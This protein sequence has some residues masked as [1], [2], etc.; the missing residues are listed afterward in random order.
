M[1][2]LT[3]K[4]VAIWWSFMWR[5]M[6]YGFVIGFVMGM[7]YA[8]GGGNASNKGF[9]LLVQLTSMVVAGLYA[10]KGALVKNNIEIN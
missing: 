6:I 10:M 9:L 2:A 4:V 7:I 3:E 8:L 5:A 1:F